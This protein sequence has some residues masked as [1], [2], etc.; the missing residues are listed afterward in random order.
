MEERPNLSVEEKHKYIKLLTDR[1]STLRAKAAVPQEELA[2][3]IGVSRQTYGAIERKD[4]EMSWGTYLALLFFFDQNKQT[5]QLLRQIGAFPGS[6][7][8][9]FNNGEDTIES[10][11][12]FLDIP[13]KEMLDALDEQGKHSIK[14][15]LMMEYARCKKISG[16]AVIKSF[17]GKTF[18]E[19]LSGDDKD[20]ALA[21]K[22]IKEKRKYG[23]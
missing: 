1:L 3:I 15:L 2:K 14:T 13:M 4:K 18:D 17:D 8:K 10:D 16:D 6:L 21:L 22:R 20:V 23:G 19:S 5:H 9:Y 7:I 12:S 11:D